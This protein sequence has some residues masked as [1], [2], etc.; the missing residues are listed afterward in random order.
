MEWLDYSKESIKKYDRISLGYNYDIKINNIDIKSNKFD[1]AS[2][3]VSKPFVVN[4]TISNITL[5]A[6]EEIVKGTDIEYYVSF[7]D[8]PT[9]KDWVPILPINRSS[10]SESSPYNVQDEI[11]FINEYNEAILRFDDGKNIQVFQDG[12]PVAFTQYTDINNHIV[13]QLPNYDPRHKYTASYVTEQDHISVSRQNYTNKIMVDTFQG[14]DD[15]NKV[16]LSKIFD[17]SQQKDHP[18][19]IKLVS[20]GGL[21][22]PKHV[23]SE[24]S[25]RSMY[26]VIEVTEQGSVLQNAVGET[27]EDDFPQLLNVSHKFEKGFTFS[28]YNSNL[29]NETGDISGSQFNMMYPYFEYYMKD[30]NIYFAEKFNKYDENGQAEIVVTYPYA[31]IPLRVKIILRNNSTNPALSPVLKKYQLNLY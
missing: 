11:L 21:I 25:Y 19:Q 3:Y 6:E 10:V 14:T 9:A 31:E 4:E 15:D 24:T 22:G 23:D 12:E 17:K 8:I 28:L 29:K 16:I 26:R 20:T 30:N 2:V 13:V 27:I 7:K 5:N 18:M 1:D